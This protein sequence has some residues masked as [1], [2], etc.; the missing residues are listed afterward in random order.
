MSYNHNDCSRSDPDPGDR[1]EREDYADR[2]AAFD[3]GLC[4]RRAAIAGGAEYL[5]DLAETMLELKEAG[6]AVPAPVAA[7]SART[8]AQPRREA[9]PH[10]ERSAA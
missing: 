9:Q 3:A 7:G 2:L 1:A 10:R 8:S 6:C 4:S 5:R